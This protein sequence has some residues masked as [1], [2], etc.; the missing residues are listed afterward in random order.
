VQH[1]PQLLQGKAAATTLGASIMGAASLQEY[2]GG[3]S[4]IQC[5]PKHA[6]EKSV[7]DV[8]KCIKAT[9]VRQ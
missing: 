5:S 1:G 8:H 2:T 7:Q 6:H 3:T 4:P 9:C